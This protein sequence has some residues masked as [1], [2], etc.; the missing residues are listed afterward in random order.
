MRLF[1]LGT[2]AGEGYPS[3]FCECDNCREARMRGGRNLRLRSAMLVNDDLLLDMGPDLVAAAHRYNLRFS[4]VRTALIT[5]AHGDHFHLP[6]IEFR[7]DSFTV[8]IR[9]PRLKIFAPGDV[10]R[11]IEKEFPNLD[12]VMVDVQAVKPF[13]TW[14]YNGYRFTSYRAYHAEGQLECL[15]Y[16]IDDGARRVLYATDTG[17]FPTATWDAL[18]GQSFDCIVLEETEGTGQWPQHMNFERFLD[19]YRRFQQQGMLRRGGRVVAHH[20]SHSSNPVHDK[21]VEILEPHGVI[22][23]YDGLT[24]GL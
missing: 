5:H 18:A 22:V 1:F 3:I 4:T 13:E 24:L 16:A 20:L 6:A 12:D 8:V 23:A 21:V 11:A 9:P 17:P 2:A 14:E 15:F 19:H 7:K 10:I